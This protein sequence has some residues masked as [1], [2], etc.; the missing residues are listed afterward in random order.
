MNVRRQPMM[1][2]VYRSHRRERAGKP[3][4][5]RI[6]LSFSEKK[7]LQGEPVA[8]AESVKVIRRNDIALLILDIC[9]MLT[10]SWVVK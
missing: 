8:L 9:G 7:T 6:R 3:L 4:L 1:G 2:P 5:K 10:W